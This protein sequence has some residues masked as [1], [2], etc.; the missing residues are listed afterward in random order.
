MQGV[1]F[2]GN[3]QDVLCALDDITISGSSTSN[4]SDL[5]GTKLR[6]GADPGRPMP[7]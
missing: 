1:R 3:D 5:P 7:V 6:Q 2:S 4:S